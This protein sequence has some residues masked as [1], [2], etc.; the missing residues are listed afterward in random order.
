MLELAQDVVGRLGRGE[1]FALATVTAIRGSAP[2]PV[3]TSMLVD[4]SGRVAGSV[5]GGCVEGAVFELCALALEEDSAHVER[6]GIDDETAFAVGLS[7]GGEL[8]VFVQ[9]FPSGAGADA[10]GEPFRRA[11]AG[12]DAGVAVVVAGPAGL[13]GRVLPAG[14]DDALTDAELDAAGLDGVRA[15]RVQAEVDRAAAS[16]R[17]GMVDVDCGEA[18]LRLF[19]ES[20]LAPPRLLVYGAIAFGDALAAAAKPLGYRV[21]VCDHRPAFA[22]PERFP[23]ADEVVV[24]RPAEHLAR[25]A[26]DERT[27]VVVL[28]HDARTDVPVLAAALERPVA[29]VGAL[30][31][32]RTHDERMRLL[33]DVGVGDAALSSLHSPIGLDLGA[34]TPAETALSI[35]AE[36][37]A[38]RTGAS[39]RPLRETTGPIHRT[40]PGTDAVVRSAP[41]AP[42][43]H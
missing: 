17:T 25:T 24:A 16:G 31:S 40:V 8:D 26:T 29:F 14:A 7:C 23:H 2:L 6:F 19:V 37:V 39:G 30:G 13:V 36:V 33:R 1:A 15:E 3:G 27:V 34:A 43:A 38:A 42:A 11:L 10:A 5:S 12:S 20:R 18:V 22:T 28:G 35:L 21:T 32:R 4:A 9:P 41:T